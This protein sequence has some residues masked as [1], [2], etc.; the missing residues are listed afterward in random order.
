MATDKEVR[1]CDFIEF[2]SIHLLNAQNKDLEE[3]MEEG[4]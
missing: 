3:P 4:A 1:N 2:I